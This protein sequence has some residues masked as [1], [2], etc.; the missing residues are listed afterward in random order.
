MAKYSDIK[1]FT[2]QTLSTDTVAS[3]A[4]GG[5]WASGGSMPAA[6][7]VGLNAGTQTSNVIA[8]GATDPPANTNQVNTSFEYDGSSWTA[9][10]AL[11]TT[12]FAGA[13]FGATNTAAIM[14]GGAASPGSATQPAVESYNGTSFTEVA[15]AN[16][17]RGETFGGA[18]TSTAGVVY[19]G[20]APG[21]S[22]ATRAE[23]ENWNGSAWTETSD[24]NTARADLA[25]S[26]E[27]YTAAI[28]VG[29]YTTTMVNNAETWNGSSW[30][31]VSEINTA[32]Y[33]LGAS[34]GSPSSVAY[35]G[36]TD[37]GAVQTKTESW[38]GSSWTEVADLS[39]GRWGIGRSSYGTSASALC[40]GGNTGSE[41]VTTTEEW[42]APSDFTQ[43]QEGQ[44]FYNS[45]A[46][47]FK[48]TL[49][50]IPAGTFASGGALNRARYTVG[51]CGVS[52]AAIC[53]GGDFYVGPPNSPSDRSNVLTES[54]NGS[55]WT[56]VGD[57][58]NDIQGVFS[59][60]GSQ[61]A[62]ITNGA[63]DSPKTY[64]ETWNGSAWSNA[65]DLNTDKQE[66][67]QAAQGSSTASL[68]VGGHPT[69][70]IV[71]QFDGS[72]WTE[73]ADL[74][75]GRAGGRNAGTTS[76]QIFFGGYNPGAPNG[77]A[78]NESWNGTSW[79]EVGDLPVGRHNHTGLGGQTQC[80]TTQG[81]GPNSLGA[82][83]PTGPNSSKAINFWDGTSWSSDADDA[84][85]KARGSG[86]GGSATDGIVCGGISD[87]NFT[88]TTTIE[89]TVDASNKTIS[90]S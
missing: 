65:P 76:A 36:T 60:A 2:V 4:A 18:G 78:K 17:A 87:P 11:N 63:S 74:N 47:A 58:N 7:Y 12:R 90:S 57:M 38:D 69:V 5:A 13:G 73:I 84:P 24:L 85:Y 40:S 19:G 54:Y 75:T 37:P 15:E 80:V 26:G 9:G 30:T 56:E 44:L 21:L 55:S 35:G 81:N 22:P 72:S 82:P 52:T 50:S 33:G 68:I 51:V 77:D 62:G 6:K 41:A 79:T 42:T 34:G 61:S 88:L 10:G 83:N 27:S 53:A 25:G 1:G 66:R 31:E 3:Q 45:T 29:G 8:G 28:C 32:R 23:T 16:T 46:N 48:E 70:A 89:W 14:V 43:I 64:I 39:A 71:E 59:M 67:C 86:G 20:R 49:K